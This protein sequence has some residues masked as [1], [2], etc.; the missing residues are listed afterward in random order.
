MTTKA[1]GDSTPCVRAYAF[2]KTTGVAF[3]AA[4]YATGDDAAPSGLA[5]D[6]V[7][8]LYVTERPPP[9][10][11]G[12]VRQAVRVLSSS[13]N[14]IGKIVG[15]TTGLEFQLAPHSQPGDPGSPAIMSIGVDSDDNLFVL[16]AG[17]TG[18]T[19]SDNHVNVYPYGADGDAPF[20]FTSQS[21]VP[22][23]P[24]GSRLGGTIP[25]QPDGDGTLMGMTISPSGLLFVSQY[26]VPWQ[27]GSVAPSAILFVQLARN[28]P[29]QTNTRGE[30]KGPSTG[31][32]TPTRMTVSDDGDLYVVD[33]D[34]ILVFGVGANGDVAPVRRI[35]GPTTGL[36]AITDIGVDHVGR[37][38]VACSPGSS[39]GEIRIF[40]ANANGDVAP[41]AVISGGIQSLTGLAIPRFKAAARSA[42]ERE[43]EAVSSLLF[44]YIQV[45]GDRRW[46]GPHP[47]GPP[48]PPGPPVDVL[49][50]SAG[51][52]LATSLDQKVA[53]LK[54]MIAAARAELER[55]QNLAATST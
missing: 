1:T 22:H 43:F 34:A 31:L 4:E 9:S 6:S 21:I 35:G 39:T 32:S 2:D 40:S 24:A 25:F 5:L 30:I 37:A 17:Y 41:H 13:G 12:M 3:V 47:I 44:S 15:P 19:V 53:A 52:Q 49:L 14:P 20:I 38:Y 23:Y 10:G 27:R 51:Y 46:G 50:A 54:I 26:Y 16:L 7:G 33:G 48:D 55:L 8:N 11:D 42:L 18:D 28:S 45:D 36:T 29:A